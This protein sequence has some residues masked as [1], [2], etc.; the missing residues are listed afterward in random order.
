MCSAAIG[1]ARDLDD[2]NDAMHL[3]LG[4]ARGKKLWDTQNSEDFGF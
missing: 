3:L 2:I 4:L 1:A